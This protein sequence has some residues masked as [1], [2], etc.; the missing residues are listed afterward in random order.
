MKKLFIAL[1]LGAFLLFVTL[2][3][4]AETVKIGMSTALTG[5]SKFLGQN[6][7][8][9]VKAYLQSVNAK[10]GVNGNTFDL[11]AYDDGYEPTKT[12]P[13]ML[14]LI[15]QDNIF[16]TLGNVGTPTAVP[17][18]KISDTFQ[19]PFFGAFTGAGLLRK[20]PPDKY[21][22]N[23]RASYVE[24]TA[25][26]VELLVQTGIKPSEIAFFIQDDAFGQAGL[27][28]GL[29]ALSKYGIKAENITVGKYTRNTV[30]VE[31]GMYKILAAKPKAV[32]L[33]GVY[34]PCSE[35]IIKAK[36]KGLD[37]I[38]LCVSFVG[39][40]ALGEKLASKGESFTKKV[41][42][43][44]V[45]PHYNSNLPVITEYKENLAK[46]S[47]G[48]EPNFVSLEGYIAAK[49]FVEACKEAGPNLTKESFI[50]AAESIKNYDPGMNHSLSFSTT[51]HQASH[52]LWPTMFNSKGIEID[53]NPS[54]L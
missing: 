5:P 45:V 18:V 40:K 54:L 29:K 19:T 47:P 44:Q 24:E 15:K 52:T 7:K 42:V 16:A 4:S 21:V 13:N 3:V 9:G 22:F 32:I 38:Y 20:N 10:G 37:S 6:M 8:A 46:Y 1:F 51:D 33:V 23:Y 53:Y 26:M 28:G 14:K 2:S 48:F 11:I 35:F 36:E 17:A 27:T 30:D 34:N 25:K 41:V 49:L 50:K 12:A 43:T 31:S 39:S